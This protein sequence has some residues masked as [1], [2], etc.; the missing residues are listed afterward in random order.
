M[1]RVAEPETLRRYHNAL[2]MQNV[3]ADLEIVSKRF[4]RN[5]QILATDPLVIPLSKIFMAHA[6]RVAGKSSPAA[7]DEAFAKIIKE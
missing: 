1:T 4:R 6:L 7:A 3:A 5:H 2:A